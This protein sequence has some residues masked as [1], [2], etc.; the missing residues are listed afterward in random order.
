MFSGSMVAIVTPMLASGEVD[1][2]AFTRLI[3][4][5]LEA[6]TDAIVALGTTGEAPTITAKER[7]KIIQHVVKRVN[8]KV[9]VIIGAG[10]NSTQHTIELTKEAMQRGADA[11]LLVTPYYNRPT[12][13][14][15]FQ[16]YSAVAKAVPLPQILYN[17]P[18]RTGCDLLPET[19]ARLSK[20]AN[21]VALKEATGSLE[22]LKELVDLNLKLDLLTGVDES[23]LDF[24]LAGGRGVISVAANIVPEQFAKLCH[25]ALAGDITLAQ[26]INQK[27]T[28]LNRLLFIESNPIP[29]KWLLAKMG[30]IESGIRLPLTPLAAEHQAA[31]SELLVSISASSIVSS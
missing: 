12:Q 7:S 23:V 3:E 19:V 15:L 29:V 8:G 21:I 11:A 17:V 30:L 18:A 25:A 31:L 27:L 13:E 16:H 22:R 9:P 2:D 10:A 28:E 26:T 6:K 5:H 20:L 24:L 4:W 14:G 1:Y